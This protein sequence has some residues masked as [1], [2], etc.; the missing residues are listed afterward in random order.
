MFP[1]TKYY[2]RPEA[3]A[4]VEFLWK[5][6]G[7]KLTWSHVDFFYFTSGGAEGLR[8]NHLPETARGAFFVFWEVLD[9]DLPC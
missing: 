5:K 6:K 4:T 2:R 7:A 3:K 8:W 1:G 9:E